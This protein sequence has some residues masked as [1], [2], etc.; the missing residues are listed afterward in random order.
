VN[1]L[2]GL[3]LSRDFAG[4]PTN[5][6][7]SPCWLP[8]SCEQR[9]GVKGRSGAESAKPLALDAP[10]SATTRD[11]QGDGGG[12]SS[13]AMHLSGLVFLELWKPIGFREAWNVLGCRLI[14]LVVCFCVLD[15]IEPYRVL[16]MLSCSMPV[17]LLDTIAFL[18]S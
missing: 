1:F 2:E 5:P 4:S 16:A 13:E 12:Q 11:S 18:T 7:P 8:L 15:A 9:R 14:F 10:S 3:N 6:P 17:I